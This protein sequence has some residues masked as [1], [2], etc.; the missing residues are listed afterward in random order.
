MNRTMLICTILAAGL[1][2]TGCD[3]FSSEE[4]SSGTVQLVGQVLNSET[5]NPVEGA[6]VRVLPYDLLFETDESG[7]FDVSVEIDSTMDLK[8]SATKNGYSSATTTVLALAG[9]T[10]NVPVF[11]LTEQGGGELQSGKAANILLLSQSSESIGVKESGSQEVASLVFQVADSL[12]RAVILSNAVEMSFSLGEQPN[13]G[14]FIYPERA[15]TDNNGQVTVNLSSGTRAG[16]VQI[17]AEALVDGRMIR[18]LP[19]SVAIHG[20]L[21]DQAHF[22]LGP[23]QFNFAGL[24]TFGLKN[25]ISVIVGDKYGNP[26]KP[27]TAVYFTPS[28]GVIQGSVMT[29]SDGGGSVDLISANP[30]PP[31]GIAI[32]TATTADEHKNTV[33]EQT[34][35]VFSGVPIVR[36]NPSVAVLDETYT[37]TVH[38]EN[39][40]P[41]VGGTN[42]SVAVEGT[43][44]KAVGHTSVQLDDTA[45]LGGMGYEN[46]V[47]GP[48]I[49]EF[50]FRAVPDLKIEEEGSPFVESITISVSGPN[51]NVQVVLTPSGSPQL[52]TQDAEMK[53]LPDGGV[54]VQVIE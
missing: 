29:D 42:I 53:L 40:N 15:K 36:V 9:R 46:V 17:V 51:G 23:K 12:G 39:G 8:I 24:R 28:H 4:E 25:P 47:R 41:L 32:I 18:S 11:R 1:F 34:P 6:F 37:L 35:V 31:D 2:V 45:F 49:T 16:V 13:G 43:K 54:E 7:V 20:G 5:N 38:D 48:G 14:E 22:T 27:G 3:A 10:V 21:P 26:V 50:T 19:V 30:L 44:V 52:V 33:I